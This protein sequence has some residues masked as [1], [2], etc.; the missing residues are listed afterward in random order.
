MSDPG[1]FALTTASLATRDQRFV[2]H[3]FTQM[4][5]W[6]ASEPLVIERG[7]GAWLTDTEGRR[8]LDGVAS[9]WTNVHGHRRREIDDAV[10]AQLDRVAHST[11]LGLANVPSIELAER[12]VALA[13]AGL[14]RV[15]Y[16]DSGSTAVEVALKMAFQHFQQRG[17]TEKRRFLALTEAYHGDT[18]GAVSVGGIDLFHQIFHPLLFQVERVPPDP[19]ALEAVLRDRGPELAAFVVEPLVQGAAGMR[20]QPPGFL[21]HAADLCRAHDVLLI[22]DEVATGF[23]RTGTMFACEQAG[24]HPDLLCVAKG[25]TGGYLPLAATLAS[26]AVFAAFLGTHAQQRTFFHGH[27]YTGNPLACAAALASLDVFARDRVLE[28]LQPVIAHLGQALAAHVA[29]LPHVAEIRQLGM[30]VGVELQADPATRTPY[31]FEAAVGARV[32]QAI[33]RH[34]VILRPL[35]PVVVLM[36]PLCVTAA[37]ID[38]LV[39]ATAAAITEVTS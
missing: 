6:Q 1:S 2:W 11:L 37:E 3:P 18:L 25:L 29:P 24:V 7:E 13:P 28:R 26:E 36:P 32:C 35:G 38:F 5:D 16:S 30:M 34:G 15:F 39:H 4:Q 9:L 33:R 21:R 22:A 12:L 19:A 14:T 20:L 10:R 8:Y 23:G 31:P 27:T 17:R